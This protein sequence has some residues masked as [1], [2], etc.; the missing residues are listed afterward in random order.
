MCNMSYRYI[1]TNNNK[2]NMHTMQ[3]RNLWSWSDLS[4]HAV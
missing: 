1:Y 2:L 3:P 4:M